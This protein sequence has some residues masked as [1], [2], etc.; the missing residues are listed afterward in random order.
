MCYS[1]KVWQQIKEYMRHHNVVPDFDQFERLFQRRLSD[2]SLR[3][4]RAFEENFSEA[5]TPQERR[6]KSLIDEHRRKLTTQFERELF[7]Q[8]KRLADAQRALKVKETKAARE[9]ER[10]ATNKVQSYTERLADLRRTELRSGDSRIYPMYH[11]PIIIRDGKENR[12]VLARY[13][14]RPKGKPPSIDRQ[15][16]GLYNA[17]RDN[18]EKFWRNEFGHAH[19]VVVLDAFYENVERDGKNAILRFGPN[20]PR[21]ML[22]ACLYSRWTERVAG[23]FWSFAAITDEPPKEI[24]A[25]GHDRC[26]VSIKEGN[27]EAWLTPGGRS[28][29]ELQSILDDVERPYYAHEVLA[30]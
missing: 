21:P 9:S 1:A 26:P 17:R 16:P 23:E 7:K 24:R 19:A 22:I 4:P 30:A 6:I 25:A 10:I 29:K 8:K 3:V 20:P 5:R 27:V 18:L 14:C 13:H 12:L 2:P 28:V 11:A 15:Y